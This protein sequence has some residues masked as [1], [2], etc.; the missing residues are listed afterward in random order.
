MIPY[1]YESNVSS[2]S[3][4]TEKQAGVGCGV[5][6]SE[7]VA[8]ADVHVIHERDERADIQSADNGDG[9]DDA[10]AGAYGSERAVYAAGVE[11]ERGETGPDA[12]EA[13]VRSGEFSG[14]DVWAVPDVDYGFIANSDFGLG[15]FC[16]SQHF[17]RIFA[18]VI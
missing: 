3:K 9:F 8:D 11:R 10:C 14:R 18:Y 5:W 4:K 17:Q 12:A 16:S 2:G 15:C 1:G 7:D 13:C 6:A